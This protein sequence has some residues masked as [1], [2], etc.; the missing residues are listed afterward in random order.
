VDVNYN[1]HA[2][3]TETARMLASQI[4]TRLAAF[5]GGRPSRDE[6]SQAT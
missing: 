2:H 1:R 4:T 5:A 3:R 6:D